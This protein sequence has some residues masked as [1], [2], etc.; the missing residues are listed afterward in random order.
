MPAFS[1]NE[2]LFFIKMEGFA[3]G[4]IL[5]LAIGIFSAVSAWSKSKNE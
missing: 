1:Y 2:K 5:G 3:V 4:V